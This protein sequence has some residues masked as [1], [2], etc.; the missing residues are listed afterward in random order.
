[1]VRPR[2]HRLL[3]LRLDGGVHYLESWTGYATGGGYR[4]QQAPGRVD[5]LWI[6]DVEGRRLVID[7]SYRA[8]STEQHRAELQQVVDSIQIAR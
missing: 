6:L 7:A 4:Y 3:G 1:V 2:R 5:R 8:A